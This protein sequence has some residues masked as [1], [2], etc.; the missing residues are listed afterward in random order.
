MPTNKGGEMGDGVCPACGD[1]EI[2][3]YQN[4]PEVF[5][6]CACDAVFGTCNLSESYA[7]VFP[8]WVKQEPAPEETFYFDFECLGSEGVT[9]RHGW[10]DRKSRCIVQIG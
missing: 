7:I 10:A 2:Q 8:S 4:C 9:R 6:C 5:E 1:R 3:R